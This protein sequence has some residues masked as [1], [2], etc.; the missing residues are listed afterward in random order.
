MIDAKIPKT[1]PRGTHA[2]LPSNGPPPV[3]GKAARRCCLAVPPLQHTT[4]LQGFVRPDYF[5]GGTLVL[6]TR[7]AATMYTPVKPNRACSYSMFIPPVTFRF[8]RTE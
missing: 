4:L 3:A 5:L 1:P 2:S 7:H 6:Y 8:S